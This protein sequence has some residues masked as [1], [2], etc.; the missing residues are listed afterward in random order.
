[1]PKA[2]NSES[3][4]VNLQFTADTAQAKR[5]LK[6][7]QDTLKSITRDPA[8]G[9][10]LDKKLA[11]A[12][13][14]A[15]ELSMHLKNAVNPNSG[16]LDFSR[17]NESIKK[18]G[19]SLSDYG[20][21][22]LMLGPQGRQAFSQLANAVAQSEIPVRRVNGALAQMGTVLKNTIR[23]Q[24]S[25]TAIHAFSGAIQTAYNYAKDLNESLNNIRIVTGYNINQM[26]KFAQTANKAAREL[27]TSTLDYTNAALIYYQQGLSDKEVE[28]RTNVTAKMANVTKQ[29]AEEVSNQ[30]TAIWNNY[31]EGADNLEYFADVITALGAATASSSKEISTGLEKFAAIGETVGLSYEYATA[32]LATV[33]ATT[34][35]SA[36]VV[37]NSF[38]T[39]FSRI[40]GL[41]LGETQDD[42]TDLNKYSAALLSVG[43]NIKD[44]SGELKDM[45]AILEETAAK[46]QHLGREQQMALAQTVGG[47]RQYTQ[48]IALMDNWDFMQK[49][50]QTAYN[51]SGALQ[52]QQDTYAEGW[53]AAAK[54]VKAAWE[55]VYHALIDEDFFIDLLNFIEKN[56]KGIKNLIGAMGG[57]P[58]I[59]TTIGS[60]VM[61]VF[62]KQMTE[63]LTHMTYSIQSL[64][65]RGRNKI[66]QE[67][68]GQ[69]DEMS[70][71]ALGAP[72]I[73]DTK[74]GEVWSANLKQQIELQGKLAQNNEHI[75]DFERQV[76]QTLMD[77]VKARQALVDEAAHE[78]DQINNTLKVEKQRQIEVA[79]NNGHTEADYNKAY[80]KWYNNRNNDTATAM[81]WSGSAHIADLLQS[82]LDFS[83]DIKNINQKNVGAAQEAATEILQSF[84]R[85]LE[86]T[87][88]GQALQEKLQELTNIPLNSVNFDNVKMRVQQLM[89]EIAEAINNGG[90]TTTEAGVAAQ[91]FQNFGGVIELLIPLLDELAESEQK[92]NGR[93]KSVG[94]AAQGASKFLDQAR[95][96]AATT[97][98]IIVGCAQS[99]AS[100]AMV[101]NQLNGIIDTWQRKDLSGIDKLMTTL[102]SVGMMA[103]MLINSFKTMGGLLNKMTSG[104]AAFNKAAWANPYVLIAAAIIGT[105]LVIGT[106][107]KQNAQKEK[108]AAEARREADKENLDKDKERV[109]QI[110]QENEELEKLTQ[111]LKSVVGAYDGTASAKENVFNAT[112][113]LLDAY[114]IEGAS[115]LLM[116]GRYDDLIK[117]VEE[118]KEAK[119]QE[120]ITE[121]EGEASENFKG[122][123]QFYEVSNVN[124]RIMKRAGGE[125]LYTQEIYEGLTEEQRKAFT[126][127]G[128]GGGTKSGV[129]I[130]DKSAQGVI[131]GYEAI[132]AFRQALLDNGVGASDSRITDLNAALDEMQQ[133]YDRAKAIVSE[134]VEL[135]DQSIGYTTLKDTEVGVENVSDALSRLTE[136]YKETSA[137]TEEAESKARLYLKTQADWNEAFTTYDAIQQ[138]RKS[139]QGGSLSEEELIALYNQLQTDA[140]RMVFFQIAFKAGASDQEIL[141]AIRTGTT[142]VEMEIHTANAS[143]LAE[144][145]NNFKKNMS[146][147]ETKDWAKKYGVS[148]GDENSLIGM[149]LRDFMGMSDTQKQAY[150]SN[151]TLTEQNLAY[152]KSKQYYKEN[153]NAEDESEKEKLLKEREELEELAKKNWDPAVAEGIQQRLTYLN[154]QLSEVESRLDEAETNML[155]G[156]ARKLLEFTSALEKAKDLKLGDTISQDELNNLTDGIDKS[157]EQYFVQNSDGT[158]TLVVSQID[159]KDAIENS[160]DGGTFS[161]E[162][163][164]QLAEL[165][166]TSNE[167]GAYQTQFGISSDIVADKLQQLALKYDNCEVALKDYKKAMANANKEP[168]KARQA[169]LDLIKALK[170]EEFK[171]AA[172]AIKDLTKNFKQLKGAEKEVANQHMKTELKKIFGEGFEIDDQFIEDHWSSVQK[173]TDGDEEIVKQGVNE[174]VEAYGKA[175]LVRDNLLAG[176]AEAFEW[177]ITLDDGEAITVADEWTNLLEGLPK[178]VRSEVVLKDGTIDVSK[179]LGAIGQIKDGAALASSFLKTLANSS[180][181]ITAEGLAELES[182]LTA[183]QSAEAVGDFDDYAENMVAFIKALSNLHIQASGNVDTR[184]GTSLGATGGGGGNSKAKQTAAKEDDNERY[185]YEEEHLS[186]IQKKLERIRKLKDRVYGKH[187]T[188]AIQ[189]EIDMLKKEIEAQKVL[190]EEVKRY[191]K[192]DY[193]AFLNGKK[194]AFQVQ[195]KDGKYVWKDL[196]GL[197]QVMQDYPEF[198]DKIR[199]IFD[200]D[201]DIVN[202]DEIK[203]ALRAIINGIIEAQNTVENVNEQN[204]EYL[205]EALA[206][207]EHL[208][209]IM[210]QLEDTRNKLTDEENKLQ[211]QLWEI[212]DAREQQI[213]DEIEFRIQLEKN[214]IKMIES[215]IRTLDWNFYKSIEVASLMEDKFNKVL[216]N[217]GRLRDDYE[218]WVSAFNNG[219]ISAEAFREH[220]QEV[221]DQAGESI[222]ELMSNWEAMRDYYSQV[223][224]DMDSRLKLETRIFGNLVDELEYYSELMDLSGHE[225]DYDKKL[226][227]LRAEQDVIKDRLAVDK[228]TQNLY[229]SEYDKLK[230]AYD[231]ALASG[232]TDRAEFLLPSVQAA[233]DKLDEINSQVRDDIKQI[234]ELAQ[235]Q[236]STTLDKVYHE[237]EQK[238]TGGLGFDYLSQTMDL[239][240]K[241]AEEY[242]TKTNQIYETS[243]LIRNINRD[244]DKTDS[245]SAKTKLGNFAKEIQALQEKGELS[246]YEL[247]D[248]K[249]RYEVLKAQIALEEAQNAKSTV[250]LQRDN[251]G[252]YGYVYTA[253]QSAVAE[254]EDN[255]AKAQNDRYNLALETQQ[256]YLRKYYDTEREAQD[257]LRQLDED[258][259][260]GRIQS[261]EEYRRRRQEI[262]EYYSDLLETYEN[263]HTQAIGVMHETAAEHM[264]DSWTAAFGDENGNG[265]IGKTA[266]WRDT[267]IESGAQVDDAL[268]ELKETIET[269]IEPEYDN[270]SEKIDNA[271]RVSSDLR[272]ELVNNFLPRVSAIVQGIN[273]MTLAWSEYAD[274]LREALKALQELQAA[275]QAQ[276]AANGGDSDSDDDFDMSI[277]YSA[278]AAEAQQRYQEALAAGDEEAAAK[279]KAEMEQAMRDREEKKRRLGSS[280]TTVSNSRIQ[281]V[282]DAANNPNDPKHD[283]AVAVLNAVNGNT[284]FFTDDFLKQHGFLTGGYTGKWPGGSSPMGGKFAMLHEKEMVLNQDDTYN[285]L[286]AVETVRKLGEVVDLRALDSRIAGRTG[287]DLDPMELGTFEQNI[288]IYAEFPGAVEHDEIRTAFDDLINRASQYAFKTNK[289]GG[290]Y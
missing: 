266:E 286:A 84:G 36:E 66:I 60:L 227:I 19:M 194:K 272:N 42:G 124:K 253:D 231:E 238:L 267:T 2:L 101:W 182:I 220:M 212:Q 254:A 52:K 34:R 14:Y 256:E 234:A 13:R 58:G 100:L 127:W 283:D 92:V 109:E 145:T 156:D 235:Q 77:Q 107:L 142:G 26:E 261:E 130:R 252:N 115:L 30:L 17:L 27:S 198:A 202:W 16:M 93:T 290:S 136:K 226:E 205:N 189:D 153:K 85:E 134:T 79:K 163:Q 243:Q 260:A 25:S 35:Q 122:L 251:E 119:R 206:Q 215:A 139:G 22:L 229:Q 73:N 285:M 230:Q 225:Q 186:E 224:D 200:E 5:E 111:N 105:L 155:E 288:T 68:R 71:S 284:A 96:K 245:V 78:Y 98:E 183:L 41:K 87:P 103:P 154:A 106:I 48:F 274:E 282:L 91:E 37:G 244:M 135:K 10:S 264:N 147:Q 262:I 246:H 281:S 117:K 76:F 187:R 259:A 203:D 8:E 140:E 223:L 150:L 50:L 83:K 221:F 46:W 159:L 132:Q 21:K 287:G 121:L 242:L 81:T 241:R 289:I 213:A 177:T 118:Y 209:D 53:E 59:L 23:W 120:R 40:Q 184:V 168:E 174:I 97:Q 28:A 141:D 265:L 166:S 128:G 275:A 24:L 57:I 6:Q 133:Y 99:I 29:S 15:A 250:R 47:V 169:Y 148:F 176:N 271:R 20:N 63:S 149:E 162:Q 263:I 280:D 113:E 151:R 12:S 193:N 179:V 38:K 277:D 278:R 247:E 152:D 222:E 110:K 116:Q 45:D 90:I 201:G 161:R 204:T 236:F 190:I 144:A 240:S 167:L 216:D 32:A 268:R 173:L 214:E 43:V 33:T 248:A 125:D 273:D 180:A 257:A 197:M 123:S 164:Q 80:Q 67:R 160:L 237:A 9:F 4:K 112:K 185:H 56:I 72:G 172:K 104:Q 138:K 1:M 74:V 232:D 143:A 207:Y 95:N 157:L 55:D 18:S 146:V 239:A 137:S 211:D 114:D 208:L 217:S 188:K 170:I 165:A 192:E 218:Q 82:S 276:M 64:T 255:L 219:E 62:G 269:V 131:N 270:L 195:D 175:Q 54:R 258:Y 3:V 7:L 94:Q 75:N 88:A 69:L 181:E 51:S 191:E 89:Q 178:E 279:A 31:A 199:P 210:Q 233:A 61:T 102:T 108:E 126:L 249:A 86:V 44:A 49:N 39:L 228:E 11:E 70:A 196:K 65:E 129:M 158:W 171:E